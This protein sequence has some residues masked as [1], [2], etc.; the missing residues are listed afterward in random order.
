MIGSIEGV[1]KINLPINMI[2]NLGEIKTAR[3]SDNVVNGMRK[4]YEEKSRMIPSTKKE[5]Y[6]KRVT[7][8]YDKLHDVKPIDNTV[9]GVIYVNNYLEKGIS[10]KPSISDLKQI[11]TEYRLI[12]NE[13][14]EKEEVKMEEKIENQESYL[15]TN[16]DEIYDRL[17]KKVDGVGVYI[18]ELNRLQDNVHKSNDQLEEEKWKFEQ[19][20]KKFEEYKKEEEEKIFKDRKDLDERIKKVESLIKLF[21]LK[22]SDITEK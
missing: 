18:N 10:V 12:Y 1:H 5:D 6:R 14:K 13:K 7:R 15:L 4:Y 2:S 3:V 9:N 19:D 22:I 8:L 20:K 11:W 17:Y 21:D 16:F